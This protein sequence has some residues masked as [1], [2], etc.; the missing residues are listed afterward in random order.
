[1][2]DDPAPASR[3]RWILAGLVAVLL[4]GAALLAPLQ[5]AT[6]GLYGYDGYYHVRYAQ[7]LRSEGVSRS[8]PWWRETFLRDR[9]ADKD[10]LYHVLLIPFTFSD[11]VQGGKAAAVVFG[12]LCLGA[13]YLVAGRLGVPWPAAWTLLLAS[14][15]TAFLYRIGFTRPL[16]LAVALALAGTGAILLGRA[17]WAFA[18]AAVY[19]HAH[20]SYHLLPCV[21]LLHDLHAGA[22]GRRGFRLAR[23]TAAGAATGAILSPYFP[24][25]LYLWWAQNVRV[26]G[27]A[28]GGPEDLRLGMEIGPGRTDDLLRYS[29]GVFAV[30]L[31]AVYLGVRSRRR[32]SRQARTLLVV[33]SG[34]LGLTMLSRRFVEFWTPFTILLAG[35]AARDALSGDAG[36]HPGGGGG[37]GLRRRRAAAAAVLLAGAVLLAPAA[38]GARRFIAADPGLYY[39]DA[40]EWMASNVPAGETI[41]HLDWDDFPQLFF[42]NPQFRYLVGLDPTFMYLT[43]PERWRLWSDV[44]HAEVEDIYTPIRSTFGSR[45]VLAVPDAEDFLERARRDPRFFVRYEDRDASVLFLAD[46]YEF[47]KRWRLT[48]W[49]PDPARRLLDVPLGPEPGS[50]PSAAPPPSGPAS[51]GIEVEARSGFV[52]LRAKLALIPTVPDACGLAEA[53]LVGGGGGPATLAL[54]TDDEARVTLNGE[55]VLVTSPFRAPEAGLPGGPPVSL[56]EFLRARAHVPETS[57]LVR[58]RGGENRLLVKGCRAGEDFGFFL[59][60]YREDGSP[61]P[62][63]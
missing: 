10:F 28:W 23:W 36:D 37:P 56:D 48:G 22:E 43:D 51:A 55:A 32:P 5:W 54:T 25:N 7:V 1:M 58:L 11:L 8:F 30:L 44:A 9:F 16:V 19:P 4:G 29:A 60:A 3:P 41:F 39:R 63:R 40:S 15:S 35:V 27:M 21:A 42:F 6:E 24:N 31:A 52:D 47:V 18:F 57:A 14:S 26:L 20:I 34:F 13:F 33:S 59:R 49:W 12:C 45:W 53:T 50:D 2:P 17:R 61:V 38:S 46:G 62:E